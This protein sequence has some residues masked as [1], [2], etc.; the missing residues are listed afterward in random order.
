MKSPRHDRGA[1]MQQLMKRM[2]PV[3]TRLTPQNR[4]GFVADGVTVEPHTF[5]VAFHVEL[6]Q[7]RSEAAQGLRYSGSTARVGSPQNVRY[8]TA[9]S[10]AS[11]GTL[12]CN[13]SPKKC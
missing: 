3:G 7:I 12:R 11:A 5:A 2:L 6:L 9:K 4:S 8:Q 10:P 13:G 1:L